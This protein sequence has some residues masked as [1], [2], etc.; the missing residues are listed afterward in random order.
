MCEVSNSTTLHTYFDWV[1]FEPILGLGDIG[2]V[3]AE[4]ALGTVKNVID[5]TEPIRGFIFP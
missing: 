4:I 1:V 5:A 3:V 2:N